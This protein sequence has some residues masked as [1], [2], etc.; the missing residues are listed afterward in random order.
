MTKTRIPANR[1]K[2]RATTALHLGLIRSTSK[3][4]NSN[5][6]SV[7]APSVDS[8]PGRITLDGVITGD[9]VTLTNET[10]HALEFQLVVNFGDRACII[11]IIARSRE[12]EVGG[13]AED[14]HAV[15]H[16]GDRVRV[17]GQ[18]EFSSNGLASLEILVYMVFAR[19]PGYHVDLTLTKRAS[20]QDFNR[21]VMYSAVSEMARKIA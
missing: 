8:D 10:T 6:Q 19:D 4:D 7:E 13:Y 9:P 12:R 17:T 15:A 5:M 1:I 20:R 18:L 14:F 3:P 2:E 11:P 21:T 16:A